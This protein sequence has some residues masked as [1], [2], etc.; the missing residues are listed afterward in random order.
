MNS[1]PATQNS[2]LNLDRLAAQRQLYSKA[3]LILGWQVCFG[4]PLAV[5]F[6]FMALSFPTMKSFAALWGMLITLADIA[7][8]SPWQKRLRSLAAQIQEQFDCDVL[9]L[10]WNEVKVGKKPLPGNN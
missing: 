10:P 7:W 3:K 2:P 1:I 8:L 9:E 6:A 4:G 5:G